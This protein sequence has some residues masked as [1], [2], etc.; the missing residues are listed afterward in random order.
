MKKL[1]FL[2]TISFLSLAA[3]QK[4]APSLGEAPSAADAEFTMAP[5]A[6]NPNIIEL[7]AANPNLQYQWDFGNGTKGQGAQVN[8]SYP[9]AGTYT[10]KLTVFAKGGSRS[11]SQEVTILEDNLGLLNNPIYGML[12][13]GISGPGFKVWAIDSAISGHFGVGPDPES[14]LGPTPEW[15]AAGPNE[16]PG[17]GLY[18]D[19]YVFH[20]NGFKFDMINHNDIYIHNSLAAA[21]PGSFQNLGDFTAP[22]SDQLNE[23]WLLTEG[24]ENT[25]TISN[26]AFIGFYTGVHTYRILSIT[27]STLSLQYKHHAGGLSWYLK[28]KAQP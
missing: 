14:A 12:T 24:T 4:Y 6:G 19:R 26:N 8:A 13:G 9:Y 28:L 7:T 25:I 15:W 17:C 18:D 27:D 3:C 10:I 20:L 2:F 11:S 1:L 22:F 5:S 21:F 23:S 16:K